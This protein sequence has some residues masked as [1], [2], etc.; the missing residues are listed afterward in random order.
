MVVT[1]E[2][3]LMGVDAT[4]AGANVVCAMCRHPPSPLPHSLTHSL[5]LT[6]MA[7][8]VVHGRHHPAVDCALLL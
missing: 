3:I 1:V 6:L 5:T 8:V 2:S 7:N 4:D